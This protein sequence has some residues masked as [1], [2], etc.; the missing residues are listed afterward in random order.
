MINIK[1]QFEELSTQMKATLAFMMC[2][3][4]QRGISILTTPIF[5]RL[6]TANEY[7]FYSIFNSWL[8]IISVFTTLKLAGSVFM[9]ALVKYLFFLHPLHKQ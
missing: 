2:S 1:K 9:Q 7:G 8:E 3:F 4:F 6:L 5:T